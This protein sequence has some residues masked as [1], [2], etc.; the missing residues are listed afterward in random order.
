MAKMRW[1][2]EYLYVGAYMQETD[3]FANQTE[4]NSVGESKTTRGSPSNRV[5]LVFYDN[6][7][8]VFTNPNGSTHM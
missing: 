2:D 6:D 1:D 7:F 5:L 4:H 3:V 8:E